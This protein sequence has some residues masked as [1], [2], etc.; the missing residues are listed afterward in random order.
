LDVEHN[1]KETNMKNSS[2]LL[3]LLVISITT[4][5]QPYNGTIFI[6]PDIITPNDPSAVQSITYTGQGTVTM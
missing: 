1:K 2:L 4:L 3:I 5:A 6:D